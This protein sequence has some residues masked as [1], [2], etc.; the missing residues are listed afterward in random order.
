MHPTSKPT[1]VLVAGCWHTSAY[2]DPLI[3][4]LAAAGYPSVAVTPR[5]VN[6]SPPATSFRPDAD[7]LEETLAG[8]QGK[9]VILVMH[10]YGGLVGTDV[11]G[12]LVASRPDVAARIA[13]MVYV[14]AFV[15]AK[16]ESLVDCK[17]SGP[18]LQFEP[19]YDLDVR[20]VSREC[21]KGCMVTES[22]RT[23][24]QS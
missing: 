20:C 19:F 4:A 7:A 22:T 13:R 23:D 14:A 12:H 10:S 11:V 24:T 21:H 18:S 2:W 1:F 3:K 15:P 16:G 6:S 9:D 8:L 5:C 17:F